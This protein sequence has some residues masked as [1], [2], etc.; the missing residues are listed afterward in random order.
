[1][2]TSQTHPIRIA[3]LTP[4]AGA[5]KI[6]VTFCPGKHQRSAVSGQW[7]RDLDL[8]LDAIADWGAAAVVSLVTSEELR[9]YKVAAMGEKVADRHMVWHHLP[10]I[11][12]SVPGERFEQEWIEVGERL[13]AL[14]R[15]GASVLIHCRGGLG[16]AGTIAARLLVELGWE[17]EEAI[18]AVRAVRP[19]AI[20]T[21]SQE[22]HVRAVQAVPEPL[23]SASV[24]AR[25]DRAV[26]ALLG[27]AVGDALG[28]TLEFSRRDS[29]PRVTDIVG[30]GPFRLEPGV[31]TDDTSMAL[32]LADSL[33][34]F[35]ALDETDLMTRFVQW[36]EDGEYSSVGR[37]V[38]IGVTTRQALARWKRTGNPLAGSTAPNTAGNGSLMRLAPIALRHWQDRERLRDV[39][40]RQSIVTHAASEAVDACVGFAEILADAIAGQPHSAVLRGRGQDLTRG[41]A[42]VLGG[43][44]RGKPRSAIRS[45]GYVVHSLETAL[46]CVGQTGSF[47]DAV[48]LAANLGDDADTVAAITGQLAGALYGASAIPSRWLDR[49]AW[50]PRIANMARSLFEESEA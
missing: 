47:E 16:R 33:F 5:G 13:R 36:H 41:I 48:V 21:R 37:C 14:L 11:D 10:I 17:A 35:P 9:A 20:E 42:A 50:C 24:E 40:A 32:A 30:G 39:A 3:E 34:A 49:L 25:R 7:A 46:W 18:R 28:T 19:G 8:D 31:W 45:T 23:P 6:G 38:D 27:L 12:A 43:S 22:M 4:F 44:W 26:G 2:K 1:M 29:Q 15:S